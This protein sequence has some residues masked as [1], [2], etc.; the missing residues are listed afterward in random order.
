MLPANDAAVMPAIVCLVVGMVNPQYG[1][2]PVLPAITP[3]A[4]LTV[5]PAPDLSAGRDL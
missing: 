4:A 3:Y 1:A 5:R 2:A